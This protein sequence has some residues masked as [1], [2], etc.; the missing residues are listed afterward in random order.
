MRKYFDSAHRAIHGEE[1]EF[2]CPTP[3]PKSS[4]SKLRSLASWAL[5]ARTKPEPEW[6]GTLDYIFVDPRLH[7]TECEVVLDQPKSPDSDIYPSDHF[8]L[9]ARFDTSPYD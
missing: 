2:T 1:P 9:Y 4:K 6:K 5:R 3:L 7:T 8:G